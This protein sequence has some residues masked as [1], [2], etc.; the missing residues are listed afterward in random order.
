[1]PLAGWLTTVAVGLLV[2]GVAGLVGIGGG[3]VMVPFLYFFLARPGLS[4]TLL[5]AGE[6]AVVAHATSLLAIVPVSMRG[7]WL[8]SRSRLVDW[9][10][11]WIL[12]AASVVLAVMG[13][14]LAVDLPADTL[15]FAFGI[16]LLVAA[17]RL[18]FGRRRS[19]DDKPLSGKTHSLR[20]VVG[21]ASVGFF[22]ALLGVGGG[23]MA[24]PVLI[25]W[26]NTPIRKVSGTSLAIIMFTAIAGVLSYTAYGILSPTS[27]RGLLPYIHFPA[28][29]AMATG[30]LV[31]INWGPR[32][33]QRLSP[34]GL[35]WLFAIMF[36]L[37]GLRLVAG[38]L[39]RLLDS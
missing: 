21:G 5:P 3:A 6:Q 10:S 20:A 29:T 2:G 39:L 4:G 7:A 34:G 36:G 13:A 28:A 12:A 19:A 32:I 33:Q 22:S 25:Y 27:G 15:K 18:L 14:R 8:Y 30:A 17:A 38:N 35:R 26:L 24:I 23:L 11:V 9:R 31:A 1:M 37:L 16:F